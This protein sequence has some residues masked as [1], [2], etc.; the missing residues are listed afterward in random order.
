MTKN[1]INK[2]P[3]KHKIRKLIGAGKQQ[4]E[5]QLISVQFV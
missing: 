5:N 2:T 1:Q 3:N 4:S